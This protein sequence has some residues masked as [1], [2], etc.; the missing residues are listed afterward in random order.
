[1]RDL[2]LSTLS[3]NGIGKRK[4]KIKNIKMDLKKSYDKESFWKE[5]HAVENIKFNP[6]FFHFE[7]QKS[8]IH[9]HI[10]AL[11]DQNRLY[12]YNPS[13]IC[14]HLRQ[15]YNNAFS[16]CETNKV[17]TNPIELFNPQ[18]SNTESQL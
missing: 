11:L 10:D 12:T 2:K 8:K 7:R 6:K 13:Q 16:Q 18:D 15:Q 5:H 3:A 14:E 9:N 17:T 4:S 1:M